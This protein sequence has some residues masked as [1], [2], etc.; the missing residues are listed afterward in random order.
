LAPLFPQLLGPSGDPVVGQQH[1][2][3]NLLQAFVNLS[4]QFADAA[5]EL[6]LESG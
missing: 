3:L 6:A 4:L 1:H 5:V 2:G